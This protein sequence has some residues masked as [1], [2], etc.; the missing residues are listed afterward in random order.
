MAKKEQFGLRSLF[1]L[2]ALVAFIT[3]ACLG[4]FGELVLILVY[5]IVLAFPILALTGLF[6]GVIAFFTDSAINLGKATLIERDNIT[7]T[8]PQALTQSQ[9][10]E[11]RHIVHR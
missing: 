7:T 6:A 3:A 9:V 11:S 2:T 1:A 5:A 8:P 4:T 10:D